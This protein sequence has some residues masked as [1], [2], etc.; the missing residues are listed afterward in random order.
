MLNQKFVLT[1]EEID[2]LGLKQGNDRNRYRLTTEL[3]EQLFEYRGLRDDKSDGIKDACDSMGV[4]V[5]DSDFMWLKNK[6]ASV[7][8]KN[9]YYKKVEEKDAEDILGKF[10]ENF[11]QK[12][13]R[14]DLPKKEVKQDGSFDRLVYTDTHVAMTPNKDGYSLYGGVWNEEQLMK[15]LNEMVTHV[16][17][18]QASD[19]LYIDDL[20]DF[21]DGF[22]AKTVRREH[23]L[24]QNM[25]NQKAFDV[26]FEFKRQM[27]DMLSQIY[28]KIVTH[29]VCES[30]HSSSFDYIVNS[31][32]KTYCEKV[33]GIEVHNF[34]KFIESYSVGN[35]TF[36]LT[37]GKDSKNLR[38]GFKP[39]LD[40]VQKEKISNYIDINGLHHPN[41]KIEFSKGDSHIWLFDG[42]T[43]D[44]FNYFNYPAFSPSSEWVQTNFK[45][46]QSGC[47][48]FNYREDGFNIYP[49]IF[50]W[51]ERTN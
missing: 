31:A 8:V 4:S 2:Y 16:V 17:R 45:R 49:L 44:R 21:F 23:D 39:F 9:P 25:D 37:H 43:S 33:Y 24:P 1:T 41:V 50:D 13:Q 38:F 48:F 40:A 11:S 7:R 15:R 5:K 36:I 14:V 51:N 22:D 27:I 47:M 30:N 6:G 3:Q 20:G 34:R 46:G 28:A 18:F 32:L 26:G 10:L 42:S 12:I 19:T 35:Y 29:N